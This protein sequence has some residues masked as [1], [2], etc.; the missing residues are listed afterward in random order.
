MDKFNER[1]RAYLTRGLLGRLAT[2]DGGGR[3]HVVPTGFRFDAD[4]G[5]IYVG[6]HDMAAT[7]KFRDVLANPLV[8][9]VVDDVAS[10]NP[11]RARGIEVRGEAEALTDAGDAPGSGAARIRITPTRIVSWGLGTESPR[12]TFDKA[13]EDRPTKKERVL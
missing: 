13:G 10:T 5:V 12:K 7:K 6:G 8:A 3:P 1:E 11:W 4:E 2:V 9:F